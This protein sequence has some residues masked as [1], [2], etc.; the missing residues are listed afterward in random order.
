MFEADA[1]VTE[2]PPIVITERDRDR[3]RALLSQ[4]ADA[5]AAALRLLRQELERADIIPEGTPPQG[6]V[7]IGSRV[8]FVEDDALAVRWGTVAFPDDYA[9]DDAIS[10]LTPL[11]GALLGLGP[12]QSISWGEGGR[13]RR[14]TV[15]EVQQPGA[16]GQTSGRPAAPGRRLRRAWTRMRR[17][18]G[19]RPR[20]RVGVR[21][22][23]RDVAPAGSDAR[24][25]LEQTPPSTTLAVP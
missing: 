8:G 6:L 20:T 4:R 17:I 1:A 13:L 12:G 3:L 24:E 19:R 10:V 9:G 5:D 22:V 16:V 14:V 21:N 23:A 7:I 18:F 25:Q 15:L 2:R 11:G